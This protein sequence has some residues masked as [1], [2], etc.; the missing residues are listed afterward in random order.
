MNDTSAFDLQVRVGVHH[1]YCL[2]R[3]FRLL[4]CQSALCSRCLRYRL[5]SDYVNDASVFDLQ[6]RVGVHHNYCLVRA[7]RLLPCQFLPCV[8]VVLGID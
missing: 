4:P 3:A 2:V 7:F 5:K 6:V 8:P 1:N